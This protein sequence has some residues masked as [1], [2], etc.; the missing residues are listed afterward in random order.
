[1][2]FINRKAY[3][4]KME[5]IRREYLK[6]GKIEEYKHLRRSIIFAFPIDKPIVVGKDFTKNDGDGLNVEI[7]WINAHLAKVNATMAPDQVKIGVVIE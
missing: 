3:R 5:K 1:M 7:K 6:A 4:R 2:F